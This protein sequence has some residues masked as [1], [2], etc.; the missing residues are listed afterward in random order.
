[1]NL[2][3]LCDME[4]DYASSK[5]ARTRDVGGLKQTLTESQRVSLLN[6][7]SMDLDLGNDML[8]KMEPTSSIH[9]TKLLS[10]S[11][12]SIKMRQFLQLERL[13]HPIKDVGLFIV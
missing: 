11:S 3:A 2:K 10:R 1:M 12:R 7:D 4:S 8:S 5:L 6:Q 13:L 9:V